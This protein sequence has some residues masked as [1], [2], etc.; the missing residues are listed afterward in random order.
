MQLMT[1]MDRPPLSELDSGLQADIIQRCWAHDPVN[2][3]TFQYILELLKPLAI[4]E[5]LNVMQLKS[6]PDSMISMQLFWLFLWHIIGV[7]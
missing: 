2:R 3:P 1:Y 4:D 7:F 6:I 5:D